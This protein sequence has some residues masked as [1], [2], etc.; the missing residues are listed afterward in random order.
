MKEVNFGGLSPDLEKVITE[1]RKLN[2]SLTIIPRVSSLLL[3]H[4]DGF[5]DAFPNQRV[6]RA[7][8]QWCLHPLPAMIP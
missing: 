3:A 1:E 5:S 7:T 4:G 8:G 6:A 2:G